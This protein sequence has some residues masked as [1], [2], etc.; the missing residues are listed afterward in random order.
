MAYP[1]V[2]Q[3]AQAIKTQL[4]TITV[5]NGYENAVNDV[6][7]PRRTAENLRPKNLD[8]VML[9]DDMVRDEEN[10]IA[11]NPAGIGWLVPFS[12]DC[13]IRQ[14]ESSTLPMDQVI[15]SFVADVQKA[16]MEIPT[17]GDL[18]TDTRLGMVEFASPESGF[19]GATVWIDVL[20]RVK[21][22]DPFS[23]MP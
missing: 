10:D 23:Q 6:V 5:A 8:I 14:P 2:E 21:E 20:I 18:A 19:E 16:L 4:E 9:Q 3:V 13:V 7:R 11:G 12:F 1:I 15:N 17:W 22:T